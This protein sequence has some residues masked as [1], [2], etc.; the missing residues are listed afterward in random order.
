MKK[1]KKVFALLLCVVLFSQINITIDVKAE[2]Q[3]NNK[4]SFEY[5][6]NEAQIMAIQHIK[7]IMNSTNKG[8]WEKGVRIKERRAIFDANNNIIAYYF[9]LEDTKYQEAG[10]VI[11]G[12]TNGTYPIIEYSTSGKSFI[13]GFSEEIIE[14]ESVAD[15]PYI[16]IYRT[17]NNIY[18]C[19]VFN[20]N[21][22]KYFDISSNDYYEV[23]DNYIYNQIDNK[24]DYSN[25]WFNILEE[26]NKTGDSN[27]PDS[28][29]SF[30]YNP[31]S[32]ESG[33]NL[34]RF[35]SLCNNSLLFKVMS[36]FSSGAVCAPTAAV[37]LCLYWVNEDEDSYG[38]LKF[39]DSW[40]DSFSYF[41]YL[42]D[43]DDINGTSEN[44]IAGAY[45]EYFMRVGLNCNANL[46]YHTNNGQDIVNEI[47]NDR[48]VHLM[49]YDHYRYGNHSVLA[50]GYY[51][52][53]YDN[54]DSIYIEIAD[55]WSHTAN[56]YVWGMCYGSWDYVSVEV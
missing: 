34:S 25:I 52:F 4:D 47:N 18:T 13:N 43:T 36:D 48:P 32:Y 29:N 33:Y 9:G 2:T 42:M 24:K 8:M 45:Q 39:Y 56:R 23:D 37:N 30:I 17:N 49:L 51:K 6:V 1:F 44:K 20:E 26:Y 16:K 28:G 27:P 54:Y 41:Y 21:E 53:E 11:T 19:K 40:D 15:N 22:C 50:V 35:R 46:H 55:G 3:T 10:Y 7:C 12:A 38:N 5:S 31:A 14:N